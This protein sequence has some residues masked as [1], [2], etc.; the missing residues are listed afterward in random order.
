[1]KFVEIIIFSF[2]FGFFVVG[3]VRGVVVVLEEV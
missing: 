1:M 3:D 2:E